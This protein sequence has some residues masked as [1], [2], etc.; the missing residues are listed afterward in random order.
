MLQIPD[1]RRDSTLEQPHRPCQYEG[2]AG[3]ATEIQEFVAGRKT[4]KC[5]IE[6]FYGDSLRVTDEQEQ[7]DV[8]VPRM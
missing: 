6:L 7:S 3:G 8:T 1:D 2:C 5:E 4:S